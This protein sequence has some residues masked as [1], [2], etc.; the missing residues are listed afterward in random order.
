MLMSSGIPEDPWQA[1][2]DQCDCTF[3]RIGWW[4]NPYIG[5]T[6]KVRLCCIW[7]EIYKQYPQFVQEIPAFMNYNEGEHVYEGEP[8]PWSSTDMD[9]PRA[10][11]YRQLA[12]Q[13]NMPLS[14]VRENFSN[15]EPPKRVAYNSLSS[16][17]F[18]A[19][20]K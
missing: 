8:R 18:S 20:E 16:A 7:A 17:D 10:V 11:W 3:Q 4:T 19:K 6:L 5:R 12:V 13:M 2:D 14:W 1:D 9:M 15:Q